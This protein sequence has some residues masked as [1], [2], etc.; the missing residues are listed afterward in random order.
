METLLPGKY[1]TFMKTTKSIFSLNCII[2]SILV[3]SLLPFV[4]SQSAA[5]GSVYFSGPT[6]SVQFDEPFALGSS[7]F[8]LEFW[9]KPDSLAEMGSIYNGR[10]PIAAAG[11]PIVSLDLSSDGSVDFVSGQFGSDCG[12]S[13][14]SGSPTNEIAAEQW[15]HIA[16]VE[17]HWVSLPIWYAVSTYLNGV[18]ISSNVL[19]RDECGYIF[20]SEWPDL[21][22]AVLGASGFAGEVG[23][24]RI[25]NRALSQAEIQTNIFRILNPTNETGLVGYWRFTEG[26]G[27]ITYDL[28]GTN[29]G[30]LYG[31]VWS[32]DL[33]N[34][35]FQPPSITQQPSNQVTSLNG[36]NAV[37]TVAV[38]GSPPLSYQWMLNGT[39]VPGGTVSAL[40]IT[41]AQLQDL[42]AY[43]V[44]VTNMLSAVLSSNAILY[45]RPFLASQFT[46]E[47]VLWGQDTNLTVNPVGSGPFSY[48]WYMNGVAIAAGT[49]QTL[50]LPAVQFTNAGLYSVVVTSPFGSV[51][52][53]PAELVVNPAGLS[54]GFSPTL[55]ISGVVGYTYIIQSAPNL[56]DTNAWMTLTNLTLTQPVEPWVDTSVD[57]SSPFFPKY[58]YRVL[59]GQ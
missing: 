29:N 1:E 38:T 9:C 15:Q 44:L 36:T 53:S 7:D 10:G 49:N 48:Q 21:T 47:T 13:P 58:Y 37:F 39:N 14:A 57:A 46:G 31:A 17:T 45:M 20:P 19:G 50:T 26:S 27:N 56:T 11:I 30:V 59:P 16:L 2:L 34:A 5:S 51:T 43:S 8:T 12:P 55:T 23:E 33:P 41:N 28:A 54:L 42:G 24:F 4:E 6:S 3:C 25:W 32:S 18:L 22:N 35:P 40:A 52:N